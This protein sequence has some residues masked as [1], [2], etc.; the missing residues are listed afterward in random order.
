MHEHHP[1]W[2]ALLASTGG[3]FGLGR[4]QILLQGSVMSSSNSLRQEVE[5]RLFLPFLGT[6]D[7]A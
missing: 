6:F 5:I 2:A 7:V 4:R 3:T 1:V